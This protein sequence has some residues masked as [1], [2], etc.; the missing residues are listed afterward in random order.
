MAKSLKSLAEVAE[1]TPYTTY[2]GSALAADPTSSGSRREKHD[3]DRTNVDE[4]D[5]LD[6]GQQLCHVWCRTHEKY[7]WHWVSIDD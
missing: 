1:V 3:V 5:E 2:K 6:E 7:E 4:R